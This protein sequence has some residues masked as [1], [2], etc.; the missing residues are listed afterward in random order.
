MLTEL[1]RLKMENFTLRIVVM[2]Q[3]L[4]QAQTERAVFIAKL[5]QAY[6]GM[7]W[8][9]QRGLVRRDEVK[10]LYPEFAPH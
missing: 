1:E 2:Q 7:E 4:Q 3:Q 10:D 8:D 9:E 6:P 5:E